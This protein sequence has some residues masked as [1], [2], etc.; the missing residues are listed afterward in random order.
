MWFVTCYLWHKKLWFF[1]SLLFSSVLFSCLLFS[2]L[3]LFG[4]S[5]FFLKQKV[6]W[7]VW[8]VWIV[9]F[10]SSLKQ[11]FG[12]S[13][14]FFFFFFWNKKWLVVKQKVCDSSCQRKSFCFWNKKLL[15]YWVHNVFFIFYVCIYCQLSF[16]TFKSKSKDFNPPQAAKKN[17]IQIQKIKGNCI[18]VV[19]QPASSVPVPIKA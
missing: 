9:W 11:K 18:I 3:L 10:F 15:F 2:S 14:F 1:S 4:V 8:V 19:Y 16:F 5:S 7:V 12:V 13:S 6:V 17:P